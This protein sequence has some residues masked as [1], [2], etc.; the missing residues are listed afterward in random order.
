[1][2]SVEFAVKDALKVARDPA[3]SGK[4]LLTFRPRDKAGRQQPPEA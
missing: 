4:V 3:R 1:V 2:A